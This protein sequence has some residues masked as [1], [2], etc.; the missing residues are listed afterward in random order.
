MRSEWNVSD[1]ND[2]DDDDQ[3]QGGMS[4]LFQEETACSQ[5]SSGS[6]HEEVDGGSV[7]SNSHN[8]EQIIVSDDEDQEEDHFRSR[9]YHKR[10]SSDDDDEVMQVDGIDDDSSCDEKSTSEDDAGDG[11]EVQNNPGEVLGDEHEGAQIPGTEQEGEKQQDVDNPDEPAAMD[12]TGQQ[13]G[14]DQSFKTAGADDEDDYSVDGVCLEF[15]RPQEILIVSLPESE[16]LAPGRYIL[17]LEFTG[18]LDDSMRG[19]YRTRHQVHGTERWG[20]ACHFEAT[21]ARKCFPC[22]DQPEF[23]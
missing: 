21:G 9:Q 15:M 18:Q 12:T 14:N 4:K 22:F 19:F 10:D 23:R 6:T 16:V 5:L 20:A 13:E 8:D 3:E 11:G 2:D 17:A 1:D 7:S